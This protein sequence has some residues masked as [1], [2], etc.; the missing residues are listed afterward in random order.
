MFYLLDLVLPFI[1]SPS[2][3]ELQVGKM[4]VYEENIENTH[5]PAPK[6]G[7]ICYL[8]KFKDGRGTWVG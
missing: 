1:P 8:V 4:R 7:S 6:F 3:D 5:S 2:N